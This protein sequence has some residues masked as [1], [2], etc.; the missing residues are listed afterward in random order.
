MIRTLT[1]QEHFKKRLRANYINL[2]SFVKQLGT[3]KHIKST[4][5][6]I[7]HDDELFIC[8]SCVLSKEILFPNMRE[9]KIF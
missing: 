5:L 1:S 6:Y 4:Y 7:I 9:M 8:V 3:C 2:S